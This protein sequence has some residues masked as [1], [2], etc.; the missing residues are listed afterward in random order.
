MISQLVKIKQIKADRAEHSLQKQQ[1]I[2][3]QANAHLNQA[4]LAACDYR[5]WRKQEE[6]RLFAQAK[7]SF[8]KLKELEQLQQHIAILHDKEATLE[9]EVAEIELQRNS[10]QDTLKQ[11]HKAALLANKATEKFKLLQQQDDI[12]REYL[13]QYQEEMEQ[14][15][16][17]IMSIGELPC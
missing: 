16:H 15:D 10:E 11:R 17:R 12:E 5:V 8:L 14:E 9:Q 4:N 1:Q 7:E 3:A 6:V 2:L 13:A